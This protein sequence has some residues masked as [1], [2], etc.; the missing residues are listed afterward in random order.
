MLV[1][2]T[3]MAHAQTGGGINLW[4]DDGKP[5]DPEKVGEAEEI[6]RAYREKT[7]SQAAP[8]AG[9]E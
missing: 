9:R 2:L 6:D 5:C 3:G 7:K 4:A 1:L 8:A